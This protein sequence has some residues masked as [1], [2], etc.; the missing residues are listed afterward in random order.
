MRCG[1]GRDLS[2]ITRRFGIGRQL[3]EASIAFCVKERT[4][5]HASQ[6][7]PVTRTTNLGASMPLSC[8]G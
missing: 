7:F 2:P 5:G 8:N 4:S 1:Q 6:L 3:P